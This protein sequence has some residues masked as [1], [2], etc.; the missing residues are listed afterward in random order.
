MNPAENIIHSSV[1]NFEYENKTAASKSNDLIESIFYSRI[2]PGLEKAISGKIPEGVRIELSKLEINIGTIA[3]EDLAEKLPERIRSSLEK[4]LDFNLTITAD[5]KN[6][7]QKQKPQRNWS[8]L[9]FIEIFLTKGYFPHAINKPLSIDD[10]VTEAIQN[11]KNEFTA[12]LKQHRTR[13]NVIRRTAFSL[14]TATFDQIILALEPLNAQWIIELRKMLLQTKIEL[15][16]N[17]Y[18]NNEFVPLLNYS[19]L[20][21]LVNNVGRE[22]SKKNFTTAILNEF[23]GVFKPLTQHALRSKQIFPGNNTT[24]KLIAEALTE[25]QGKGNKMSTP[26]INAEIPLTKILRMLNSGKTDFSNSQQNLLSEELT[27]AIQNNKKRKQLI[28]KLNETGAL[29][30]LELIDKEKARDLFQLITSF[31]KEV[32]DRLGKTTS[33]K[34]QTVNELVMQS[35]LYLQEKAVRKLN[36]EEFILY[37]MYSAGLEES[38]TTGSPVFRQFIETRKNIRPE[39][40]SSILKAEQKFHEISEIHQLLSKKGKDRTQAASSVNLEY[41]KIYRKKIIG[42]FLSSGHLPPAFSNL[43]LPDVQQ[44]FTKLLEQK[45]A[46][47]AELIK[48]NDNANDFV[49]RLNLLKSNLPAEVLHHY[50]THFFKEEFAVLTQAIDEIAQNFTFHSGRLYSG[51]FVD[52]IFMLALAKRKGSSM[53]VFTFFVLEQLNVE[54]ARDATNPDNFSRFIANKTGVLQQL[55]FQNKQIQHFI[56]QLVAYSKTADNLISREF[57][58][59]NIL[60]FLLQILPEEQQLTTETFAHLFAGHLH[61]TLPATGKE[62]LLSLF[63]NNLQVSGS[64]E[65]EE[66]GKLLRTSQEKTLLEPSQ[67]EKIDLYFSVLD[68]YA[69]NEFFPWWTVNISIPELLGKE[70]ILKQQTDKFPKAI[71][72]KLKSTPKKHLSRAEI[73]KLQ[74]KTETGKSSGEGEFNINDFI[75]A[76]GNNGKILFRLLYK[77]T[78]EQILGRWLANRPEIETQIREYLS[79]TPY[80]YFRNVTPPLWR[81]AVYQFS[82]EYYGQENKNKTDL[83]HTHFLNNLKKRYGHVNWPEILTHVYRAVVSEKKTFPAALVQLLK[84]QTPLRSVTNEHEKQESHSLPT[85][86]TEMKTIIYNAGLIIVWPFLTRLFEQLSLLK[87]GD[88]VNA[89]SRNRAVYLLQYLV[90]NEINFPEYEL[91]LNKL[92]SGMPP[93]IHLEPFVELTAA[94]KDM[95]KSLLNGLISNWEK[96]HNS[97]PEGIQETFLQREG[98]LQF[99]AEEVLLT[100]EKKGV[101]V[102]LQSVP[103]NLS[104][105]K[106]S[107]MQKPIHVEWI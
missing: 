29:R 77:W 100:V 93:E 46:L 44:I 81:Q 101:D 47:L 91:V 32:I 53:A 41:L 9:T 35:A 11:Y 8:I 85:N 65:L 88:F 82:L 3:E 57:R 4:A 36:L 54:L 71:R 92:L 79:I 72:K 89:E 43:T 7:N 60:H 52:E 103:W 17:H 26:K 16:L 102:L 66:L 45:D 39:K 28:N 83:F 10:L 13:D 104:V 49:A 96:V 64:K 15:N 34:T 75:K 48:K 24:V 73:R 84:P 59:L 31:A 20:K 98:M 99:K 58:R 80:F 5:G 68:F 23:S 67:P 51:A 107:W 33:G 70:H 63:A 30:L 106:L 74:K 78:D 12:V 69:E 105:I 61:E 62:K 37:L 95:T 56:E 19:I 87:Q 14:K 50:L 42:Y 76:A 90:Y 55:P 27:R 18:R 97:T 40:L 22:F 25:I 2:L 1:I 38:E 94:E 21:Y 6:D 86:E